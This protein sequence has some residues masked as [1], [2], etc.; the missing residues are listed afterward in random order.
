M[1]IIF[2][3]GKGGVGKT[4]S[5]AAT[6]IRAA[7]FGH[8]VVIMST[9]P[10]HSLSDSLGILLSAQIQN[11]MPNLDGVEVDP[12][13]ELNENWGV[14]RDFMASL[15]VTLGADNSTAGELASIPGM[16]ELFSLLRL[17]DFYST[18]KYDVV[19]VDM[20]PTGESLRLLSLPDVLTWLLKITR[21]IE[22][23]IL[24]PVLRPL[25]KLTPG[26]DKLVAPEKV[27][28]VW[29]RSLD[30]LKDIREIMDKKA[31]TSARLVMNPEKMVIAES[32]RALTYLNLYGM[33]VDAAIVNKVIPDN[34]KDGYLAE[35]HESQKKHLQTIENDFAPMPILKVPLFRNEITGIEK[36][37]ELG[38]AMYGET[39]DPAALLYDEKPISIR[40]ESDGPILRLKLP[41]ATT[42]KLEL[43]RLGSN[44]TLSVGNRYR[45]IVLPDSL[46][47]LNPQGAEMVDGYLEIKFLPSLQPEEMK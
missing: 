22:K 15:L 40:Q 5:A 7:D 27:V 31:V 45:E 43:I 33:S 42:E 18:G 23:F 24:G 2:F 21:T 38:L 35:W 19:V 36:L 39:T 1:R 9:D 30:K 20:A 3:T 47:G 41:F 44:L 14:I 12:Y 13:V 37:K 34:A 46:A 10:A 29:D 28:G 8:R 25:S 16:A 26:L 4:S 11:I 17:R 6:A 32:R